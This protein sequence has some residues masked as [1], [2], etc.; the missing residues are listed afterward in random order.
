MMSDPAQEGET[1]RLFLSFTIFYYIMLY[2]AY[3]MLL[4]LYILAV[5]ALGQM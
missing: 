3:I 5:S 4:K 1:M 2:N